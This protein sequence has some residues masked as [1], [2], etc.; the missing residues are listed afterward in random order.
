MKEYLDSRELVHSVGPV[1]VAV[2]ALALAPRWQ[3]PLLSPGSEAMYPLFVLGFL[4][5]LAALYAPRGR[6]TL[7]LG[8]IV[9]PSALWYFG[10]AWA[11]W[12]AVGIYL[13]R[14]ILRRLLYGEA[15][16]RAKTIRILPTVAD[17]SRLALATLAGGAVWVRGAG[18]RTDLSD[19]AR[20]SRWCLVG[21]LTYALTLLLL[22]VVAERF[23]RRSSSGWP[24]NLVTSLGLDASGWILG[25]ILVRTVGGVGW[26]ETL[27]LL[28]AIALLALETA[29]S[30]HLR[31][32]ALERVAELWD[33]TRAGHR[34]IFRDPDLAGIA[35][36][37]LE[38]CRN[39]LP[40]H[41]FQF[42]LL[43]AG[44]ASESWF[45]G[46][47]GQI[48]EGIPQPAES[49]PALPGIHRRTSWKI[50]GRELKG[51][52]EPIARLRFWCDPRRLENTSVDLLD[53]LLPQI[54]ASV[55]RA[56]LDRRAKQD[57][58]TGLADRRVLEVRLEQTFVASRE[59]GSSMGVIMVDLDRF[60]RVNDK[61][62]HEVGDRALLQV[63][64]VLEKHRRDTD[65]CCRYGGE[66]F[67]V[68]LEN[69][70]GD[71]A[72]QVAERL[73]LEV[74][75]TDFRADN[76]RIPLR[77]S[78]GVAAYPDLQVRSGKELL[79]LADEA[80]IEAKRSGRNRS[81]LHLGRARFRT[82]GGNTVGDAEPP[83]P[84][85]PTLF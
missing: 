37:V 3:P 11:G 33:V 74:E 66:E 10:V 48:E 83:A 18:G 40:I 32:R 70:D 45:A 82:A 72:M 69:T 19:L 60:K 85:I 80:L 58:L 26:P 42:E 73:R 62:G 13:V 34:I 68:V 14:E 63:V 77:L 27:L 23:L 51:D 61:Y 16:Q 36:Q 57:P 30:S 1:V 76:T 15:L 50:L 29:R 53:S 39:V 35:R 41:W 5:V 38:E 46:P 78:A 12:L 64:S 65:L 4:G 49:P 71:T 75:R 55:H 20:F 17:G 67:A 79:R 52:S 25:A 56:L 8:T 7:A 54:A 22:Q 31:R 9:L 28:G 43:S 59:S 84:E 81:L 47:D 44:S 2:L 21:L 6:H 24:R